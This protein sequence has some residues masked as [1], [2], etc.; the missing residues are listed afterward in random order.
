LSLLGR[1]DAKLG[2]NDSII[3]QR[4][5]QGLKRLRQRS[6]EEILDA[7]ERIMPLPGVR[8]L[9]VGCAYG[10]FLESALLRNMVPL[11]IEPDEEV[12]SI[13][14]RVGLNIKKGYF[15]DVL[16]AGSRFDVIT[17]NDVLEHL[18]N[19]PDILAG[20]RRLLAPNGK[21]VITIP[22]S[23]GVFFR[24]GSLLAQLGYRA[25]FHRLWQKD[26]PSPHLAY[27]NQANLQA[28][29][30]KNGFRFLHG[31]GLPCVDLHGLWPRLNM[32]R[33][34]PSLSSIGLYLLL[35][36]AIPVLTTVAPTDQF[37]HIYEPTS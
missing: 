23:N 33:K 28:L 30:R 19:I 7:L 13:G 32:D 2:A 17:F 31:Q 1:S 9:D 14:L 36:P 6:Y 25:P 11:G 21:L 16:P 12:A 27:F 4:R 26:Y 20:C 18:Q 22:D 37:Y 35:V 34:S 8:L 5:S 29:T 3:E 24:V 15:P 10:W